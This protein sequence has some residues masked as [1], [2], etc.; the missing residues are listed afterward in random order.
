MVGQSNQNFNDICLLQVKNQIY[1]KDIYSEYSNT[2]LF[3]FYSC[4]GQR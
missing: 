1:P 3:V 4:F 2:P